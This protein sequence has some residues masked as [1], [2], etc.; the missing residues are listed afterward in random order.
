[1]ITDEEMWIIPVTTKEA[2]IEYLVTMDSSR[3]S[4]REQAVEWVKTQPN[5]E[6]VGELR[7][8]FHVL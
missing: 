3:E 4:A 7:T 5:L 2:T 8:P 6:D 1:M